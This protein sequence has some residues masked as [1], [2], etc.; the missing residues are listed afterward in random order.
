MQAQ[1]IPLFIVNDVSANIAYLEKH[2]GFSVR[3]I[4]DGGEFAIVSYQEAFLMLESR[5]LYASSRSVSFGEPAAGQGMEILIKVS[6]VDEVYQAA[7]V[8]GATIVRV[9]HSVAETVE[10]NIRRFSVALPDGFVITFF[11]YVHTE[12]Y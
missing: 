5:R 9:I 8:S 11:N 3:R 4:A 1:I 7:R 10:F 6:D 2:L 12:W